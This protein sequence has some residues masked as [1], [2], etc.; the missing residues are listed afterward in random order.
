MFD[1]RNLPDV[2]GLSPDSL[3]GSESFIDAAHVGSDELHLQFRERTIGRDPLSLHET[4]ALRAI[5]RDVPDDA[6]APDVRDER[7]LGRPARVHPRRH[8]RRR[9]PGAPDRQ[10]RRL[11]ADGRW[12]VLLDRDVRRAADGADREARDGAGRRGL[13]LRGHRG[14][15]PSLLVR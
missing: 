2:N 4:T 12:H 3:R 11:H 15:D 10:L 13:R 8:G 1:P 7:L 9:R 6:L 14:G 5:G